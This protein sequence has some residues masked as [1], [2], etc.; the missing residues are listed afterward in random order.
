[1]EIALKNNRTNKIIFT[2]FT[3]FLIARAVIMLDPMNIVLSSTGAVFELEF[4]NI[5]FLVLTVLYCVIAGMIFWGVYKETGK[6]IIPLIILLISDPKYLVLQSN[7][8]ELAVGILMLIT[9]F[10]ILKLDQ[11]AGDI[12]VWIFSFISAAILPMSLFSTFP[13][14]LCI[15][16]FSEAKD[17]RRFYPLAVSGIIFAAASVIRVLVYKRNTLFF[18]KTMYTYSESGDFF[19]KIGYT[20]GSSDFYAYFVTA[21]AVIMLFC[22]YFKLNSH[23]SAT[24]KKGAGKLKKQIRGEYLVAGIGMLITAAGELA[25]HRYSIAFSLVWIIFILLVRCGDDTAGKILLKLNE[26]VNNHFMLFMFVLMIIAGISI[27]I[28]GCSTLYRKIG[29][30]FIG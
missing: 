2:A 17:K 28:N 30:D 13:V 26:F 18:A 19:D 9:A 12:A 25:Y 14:V 4:K 20:V 1:M 5:L 24:V 8:F 29:F 3:V 22:Y 23:I 7:I 21:A 15:R 16:Y 10:V 11:R 6:D 27:K